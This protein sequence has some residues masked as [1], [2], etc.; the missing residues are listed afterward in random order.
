MTKIGHNELMSP[1]DQT[2]VVSIW[3]RIIQYDEKTPW[4]QN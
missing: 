4:Q 3:A 2:F 1:Q